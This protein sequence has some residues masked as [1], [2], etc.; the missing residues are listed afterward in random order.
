MRLPDGHEINLVSPPVFIA[1][2]IEAFRDRGNNDYMAS[3]DLEDV[4]S[5]I[6]GRDEL[7]A[8][9]STSDK[10]LKQYLGEQFRGLLETRA[11]QEAL[12]GYLSGDSASQARLSQ[13]MEKLRLLAKIE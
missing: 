13:I 7:M 9:V 3:H 2:K 8:E 11:F 12:P 6:D 5:V 4:I 10:A 1:T